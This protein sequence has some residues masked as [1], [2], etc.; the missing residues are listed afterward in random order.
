[1]QDKRQFTR[2]PFDADAHL[3]TP[4]GSWDTHVM[5]ISLRGALMAF[6]EDGGVETG[7][8]VTL[9]LTLSDK[10]TQ[11]IMEGEIRYLR[12]QRLGVEFSHIDLESASHL[13][14]LVELNV[15]SQEMLE[16]ELDAL[17]K[18]HTSE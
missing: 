13:R 1:M 3:E 4:T 2:I 11:I 15:G 10:Q 16:R 7:T 8:P 18:I 5:D 6:P 17:W 9:V 14:R 12:E